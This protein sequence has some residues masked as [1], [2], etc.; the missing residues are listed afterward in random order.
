MTI[1]D[2]EEY[3]LEKVLYDETL[4]KYN[5]YRTEKKMPPISMKPEEASEAAAL[6]TALKR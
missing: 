4:V 3:N 2:T 5:K 1:A 6:T